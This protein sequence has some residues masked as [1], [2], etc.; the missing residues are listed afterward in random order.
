MPNPSTPRTRSRR[1]GSAAATRACGHPKDVPTRTTPPERTPG[2]LSRCSMA[3]RSALRAGA[4]SSC[5]SRHSRTSGTSTSAPAPASA[6]ASRAIARW[7]GPGMVAPWRI[8]HPGRGVRP[9][10]GRWRRARMASSPLPIRTFSLTTPG[11]GLPGLA[12][13]QAVTHRSVLNTYRQ[14]M[15]HRP[16]G[17]PAFG[18]C[19]RQTSAEQRLKVRR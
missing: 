5:N 13:A 8:T 3:R 15:I 12:L 17:L 4:G 6:A 19:L 7:S 18:R 10:A 2:S 11:V 1:A 16:P 14:P 9:P